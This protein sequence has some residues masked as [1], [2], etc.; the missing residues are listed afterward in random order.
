DYR[1]QEMDSVA[2]A[3]ARRRLLEVAESMPG[4]HSAARVNS[5]LFRTNTMSLRVPGIDS[6]EAFG[7]FNVQVASRRYF[8]VMQT[9]IVQGRGFTASDDVR[10]PR[11]AVVSASMA[12]VL[13]PGGDAIGSCMYVTWTTGPENPPC[14]TVVGIA[15]DV[16]TQSLTDDVRFTYYLNAEQMGPGWAGRLYVRLVESPT[17]ALVERVRAGLQAVM[18]GDG[19]VVVRRLQEVVDDQ[20]RSWRLGSTLFLAFGGLAVVVAAV[21]LY[22]VIAY[23]VTQRMHELGMRIALGA[24]R[25]HILR[26][27]LRQGLGFAA[28]GVVIGLTV[29]AAASR[30]L[31][32]LLYKQSSR[33]PLV[34]ATVCAI[35]VAVGALASLGPAL[36]A[37]RADPSR[38]LRVD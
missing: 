4:V 25:Q 3:A 8:D 30:W 13:W 33:D 35:M 27:V 14:T 5:M 24:R 32:P 22:G 11:V 1:G 26:L 37:V 2:E 12:R 9:R 31:E 34:F 29:A 10:A 21:G 23:T 36:R 16:A 20:R 38:A 6:A 17:P 18:P 28:G 19:F 15:G 7:R